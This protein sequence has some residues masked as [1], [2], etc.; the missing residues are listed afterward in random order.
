MEFKFECKYCGHSWERNFLRFSDADG[1]CCPVCKDT[2]IKQ[3]TKD[4]DKGDFF[5]Y[6][7]DKAQRDAYIKGK[8]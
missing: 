4:T 7:S 1:L 8:K 3:I 5:G 2:N 6:E